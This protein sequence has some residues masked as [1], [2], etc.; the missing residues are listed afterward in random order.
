MMMK[1]IIRRDMAKTA[2]AE[3][4][5]SFE[6][7]F[8]ILTNALI[9][10][11]YPKLDRMKL[12]FQLIE[13]TD[14]NND[15]CGAA[16]YVVGGTVIMIP[17]F[18]RNSKIKTG[19]MMFLPSTQQFIPMSDPWLAWV[20][21]KELGQPGEAVPEDL[22]GQNGNVM[23]AETIRQYTDPIV[24]TGSVYLRGL[25][26][27]D[28]DLTKRNADVSLLDTVIGM[29]KHASGA[30]LDN[31]I[32]DNSFLNASLRF[33][34]GDELD[35]FAKKASALA[36][37]MNTTQVVLPFTKEAKEL[38][39]D[40]KAILD[41]DGYIIKKAAKDYP[42][43][44]RVKNVRNT[45]GKLSRTGK[46]NMLAMDGT[47]HN[48]LVLR[49]GDIDTWMDSE[50]GCCYGK[51]SPYPRGRETYGQPGPACL[52]SES[53]GLFCVISTKDATSPLTLPSNAMVMLNG[54]D[55]FKPEM[56][57]GYGRAA[58]P[59]SVPKIKYGTWLLCPDGTAYR[60]H[61]A[62]AYAHNRGWCTRDSF[63]ISISDNPGQTS[64]ISTR[65]SLTIPQ[66]SRM[67]VEPDTDEGMKLTTDS[68]DNV[69]EMKDDTD[70]LKVKG[71]HMF[72]FVT[73]QTLDAFLTAYTQKNYNKVTVKSD[74]YETYIDGERMSVKEASLQLV[75]KYGVEPGVARSML[76]EVHAKA[77]PH[78]IGSESFYIAKTAAAG[79]DGWQQSNI[80][81]SQHT[82]IGPVTNLVAMPTVLED[83]ER[84]KQV[85]TRAAEQGIKEVFDVTAF[86][87]LIRQN[88]FLEEIHDDLPLFMQTLDSLCRK[89]FLFYWHTKEFEDQYG[90]VK[91]KALE[92]SIKNT[93]DSLSELT[94]FFKMRTAD[95]DNGIGQDGGELMQGHDL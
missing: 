4:G 39:A 32:G 46:M 86:K 94:I 78:S 19:D 31:L 41:R 88:R 40:E 11:K 69:V 73:A 57:E 22:A 30:L 74:G 45:F 84:L 3:D 66:G 8:G 44:I 95:G 21:E 70:K 12:A 13:K 53:K 52:N 71:K 17:S 83:P 60:M 91:M 43:V 47:I 77:L 93:M 64:P 18:Y 29:G 36:E 85:A 42:D 87:L 23:S 16:V 76:A 50:I 58:S 79:E 9:A 92:D 90:T 6:Q 75:D 82:N 25:L 2:A 68:D 27:V 34:S 5:P 35:G 26:H 15:A 28:H 62:E 89:L 20:Q 10:D 7:Q 37:D 33:Y 61:G 72:V 81:M 49:Q 67:L 56:L 63:I 65:T 80:P 48:C 59:S 1:L 54:N 38:T 24:K 51:E 14:D 55:D